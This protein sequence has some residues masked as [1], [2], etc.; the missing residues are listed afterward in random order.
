MEELQP[1]APPKKKHRTEVQKWAIIGYS[2]SLYN[3]VQRKVPRGAA[4][5][6]EGRVGLTLQAIRNMMDDYFHQI[7]ENCIHRCPD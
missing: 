2:V 3:A 5:I 7:A 4:A 6:L 1:Q